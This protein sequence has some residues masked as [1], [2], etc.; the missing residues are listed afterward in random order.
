[1]DFSGFYLKKILE[2][3]K[4]IV[5]SFSFCDCM[6]IEFFPMIGE[7]KAGVSIRALFLPKILWKRVFFGKKYRRSPRIGVRLVYV[8]GLWSLGDPFPFSSLDLLF[9]ICF[10]IKIQLFF[11]HFTVNFIQLFLKMVFI[12]FMMLQNGS[13][14][15]QNCNKDFHLV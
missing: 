5:V 9:F 7:I 6:W 12:H 8:I 2:V 4:H 1:M 3:W 14:M 15:F 11:L 10:N 13:I